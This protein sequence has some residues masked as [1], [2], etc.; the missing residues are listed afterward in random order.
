MNTRST[1]SYFCGSI[2]FA[3]VA[4]I[5][6]FCYGAS[7]HGVAIG[8]SFMFSALVLSVL[9]TSVS[10]DNAVVN[11]TILKHMSPLGRRI[12]LTLGILIAVFGVRMVL[13]IF[14][15]QFTGGVGFFE[16]AQVPFNDPDRYVQIMHHA[17]PMIMGFGGGFLLMVAIEF[18]INSEKE[19]HW[20]PAI[21]PLFAKLGSIE[22][23]QT[24]SAAMIIAI[25]S[26]F[27]P[28]ETRATF[29]GSTFTGYVVY[30]LVHMFK[31]LIGGADIIA[32]VQKSWV[33]GFVYLEVLDA[34]FSLDGVVAAFAI[35][36]N[37]ILI[38][39]GLGI[40]AMF[41]RS[42]T[43]YLVD[44]EVMEQFQYLEHSAFWSILVLVGIMFASVLHIECGELFT[45]LISA[46]IIAM[47]VI[48]SI[49][50][51]KKISQAE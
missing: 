42:L 25:I 36:S 39:I 17:H 30:M 2:V 21:E 12:F 49:I 35:T 6:A 50:A 41:V 16:A 15:V 24:F 14:I 22:N 47:G 27:M 46:A 8:F 20:I 19:E 23:I 4:L 13:P 40:G 51:K 3:I 48:T 43:I 38:A 29:V 5:A 10:L 9:E 1:L 45:G 11:A 26:F 34:S 28:A 37:F 18:F 44:R 7:T 32:A 33:V 31:N